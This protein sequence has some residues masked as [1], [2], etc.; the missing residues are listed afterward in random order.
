MSPIAYTLQHLAER[1]LAEQAALEAR[2]APTAHEDH[3]HRAL[4]GT[5][6]MQEAGQR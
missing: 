2:G 1:L 5:L 4:Y 3:A 6:R